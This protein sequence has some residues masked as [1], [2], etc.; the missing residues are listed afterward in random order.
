M[1]RNFT[2]P[3]SAATPN[4]R[5]IPELEGYFLGKRDTGVLSSL[6]L[7]ICLGVVAPRRASCDRLHLT[8]VFSSPRFH[9]WVLLMLPLPTDCLALRAAAIGLFEPLGPAI[10]RWL[11]S[12]ALL[13]SPDD[14]NTCLL[15]VSRRPWYQFTSSSQIVAYPGD[16]ALL[17]F[18]Q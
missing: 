11:P 7:E 18:F 1:S 8:V 6:V 12:L 2:P 15:G 9:L 14:Y 5:G 10:F 4:L 3:T 17:M 13:S 16:F